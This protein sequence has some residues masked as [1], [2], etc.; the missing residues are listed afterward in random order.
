MKLSKSELALCA[1]NFGE[2]QE[3]TL[4]QGEVRHPAMRE[5]CRKLSLILK[6]WVLRENRIHELPFL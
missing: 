1:L 3:L 4:L 5:V 2:E 6:T